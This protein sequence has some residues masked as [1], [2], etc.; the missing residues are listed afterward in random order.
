[1]RAYPNYSEL[2]EVL[3]DL[4]EAYRA[5]YTRKE[6]LALE[7]GCGSGITTSYILGS[8]EDLVLEAI[9]SE[10]KMIRKITG[11]LNPSIQEGRLRVKEADALEHLRTI[12][13][14]YFD[15]V[16]S[17][18]TLHNLLS[19]YR[20]ELVRQIYRCL[21][22]NGLFINAD[23]YAPD[24]D[25]LRFAELGTQLNRFFE[26]LLPLGKE[27]LLVEWVLHNVADQAPERVMR[28]G[29]ALAE[30]FEAGF[31]EVKVLYRH[32]LEAV[33]KGEK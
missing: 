19:G 23:K 28:E 33:V 2:H 10:P 8:R 13:D 9:D 7:I 1:M 17:G 14:D 22:P 32:G 31:R 25:E 20:N 29:E 4:I 11:N 16:V 12:Y 26:A 6:V 24:D 27:E 30:M 18:F 3:A 21:K 5:S 15:L